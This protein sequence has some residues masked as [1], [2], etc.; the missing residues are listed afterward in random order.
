MVVFCN[1]LAQKTPFP[2][3]DGSYLSEIPLV[4][5]KYQDGKLYMINFKH[6]LITAKISET[7]SDVDDVDTKKPAGLTAFEEQKLID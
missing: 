6:Q 1:Y 5:Q 7:E 4:C 2:Y 3:Y